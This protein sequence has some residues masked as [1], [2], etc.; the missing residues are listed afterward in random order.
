MLLLSTL[1]VFFFRRKLEMLRFL[2]RAIDFRLR[3]NPRV[4]TGGKCDLRRERRQEAPVA[5]G[6]C[7]Q[8][9]SA[10]LGIGLAGKRLKLHWE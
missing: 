7:F 3:E 10:G 5:N 9:L 8:P 6:C 2:F 4:V 1:T